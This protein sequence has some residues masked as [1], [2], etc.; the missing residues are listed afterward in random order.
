MLRCAE[1]GKE[2]RSGEQVAWEDDEVI[3]LQCPE[4]PKPC[5]ECHLVHAGE[6]F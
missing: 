1:C 3:H 2:I 4:Q 6:C 5:E